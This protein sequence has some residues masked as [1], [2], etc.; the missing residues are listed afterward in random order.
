MRVE[1]VKA[2]KY[3]RIGDNVTLWVNEENPNYV[4]DDLW[5]QCFSLLGRKK[6]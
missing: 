4:T 5:E 3:G 2:K 6:Q 1:Q